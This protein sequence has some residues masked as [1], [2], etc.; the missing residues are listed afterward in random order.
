[1]HD[2]A[3]HRMDRVGARW[4]QAALTGPE[5]LVPPAVPRPNRALI[6]WPAPVRHELGRRTAKL[7]AAPV[8]GDAASLSKIDRAKTFG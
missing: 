5:I 1:M 3:A 4:L 8:G 7:V 6:L 2:A